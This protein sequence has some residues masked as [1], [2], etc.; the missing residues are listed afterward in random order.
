M[1]GGG[2]GG[3]AEGRGGLCPK[4]QNARWGG[5]VTRREGQGGEWWGW[6]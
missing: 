2:G 1:G 4:L 5:G 6:M 3:G